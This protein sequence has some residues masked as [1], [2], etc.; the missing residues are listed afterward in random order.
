ML[1]D[2]KR[3]EGMYRGLLWKIYCKVTKRHLPYGI[4]HFYLP[5]DMVEHGPP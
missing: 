2:I 1:K 5:P 3:F 4:I